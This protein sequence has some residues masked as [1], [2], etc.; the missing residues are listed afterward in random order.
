[1]RICASSS[2]RSTDCRRVV[3]LARRA[4]RV[5]FVLAAPSSANMT[6]RTELSW[7][8]P[9]TSVSRV[10]ERM[11]G[12][13]LFSRLPPL[14]FRKGAGR[15]SS[16]KTKGFRDRSARLRSRRSARM[17]SGWGR[18]PFA[19]FADPFLEAAE[20][21]DFKSGKPIVRIGSG[22]TRAMSWNYP[23]SFECFESQRIGARGHRPTQVGADSND[24]AFCLHAGRSFHSRLSAVC[25]IHALRSIQQRAVELDGDA[26]PKEVDRHDEEAFLG[27]SSDQ[28]AFHVSER[29]VG[30]AHALPYPQIGIG[31]DREVG[32]DNLLD[33]FDLRIGNDLEPVP[34]LAEHPHQAACLVN[35]EVACLVDRVTQEEI[36]SEERN[37][38][39][40][41][42][43]TASRP[44][45][46]RRQEEV[47]ALRSELVANELLAIAA[48]PED[49][50]GRGHRV[51]SGFQQGFAPLV[52]VPFSGE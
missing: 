24:E 28:D 49:A 22:K 3:T 11:A 18:R 9:A 30:D 37:G 31:K 34:P 44:C 19:S 7:C 15:S 47:K 27:I 32:V 12:T 26:A 51:P 13:V 43:P 29:P 42:H 2:A 25:V 1:M 21:R 17:N 45:L 36:T 40:D 41:P 50:P 46:G 8:Q 52:S 5:D 35:L 33:R 14:L 39:A 16:I 23:V 20:N 4:P 48:R 6:P 38:A 10:E